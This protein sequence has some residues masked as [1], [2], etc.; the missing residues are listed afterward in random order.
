MGAFE[1]VGENC[2]AEAVG[3]VVGCVD[4][5][6]FR[7]EAGDYYD[8]TWITWSVLDESWTMGKE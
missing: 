4:G 8:G 7:C 3:C 6:G 5:F 2:G 1:I